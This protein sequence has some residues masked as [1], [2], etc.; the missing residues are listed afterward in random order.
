VPTDQRKR[1]SAP[2]A[3]K[4]KVSDLSAVLSG[5]S[6]DKYESRRAR[7]TEEQDRLLLQHRAR[8]LGWRQLSK[9]FGLHENTL[10]RRYFDLTKA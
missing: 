6:P 9:A 8:G 3:V 4:M 7:F 1:L 2:K 10:R 5:M